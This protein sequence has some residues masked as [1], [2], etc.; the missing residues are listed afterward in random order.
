MMTLCYCYT[1]WWFN[2]TKPAC[3]SAHR[4]GSATAA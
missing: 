4:K 3:S 1:A 2:C